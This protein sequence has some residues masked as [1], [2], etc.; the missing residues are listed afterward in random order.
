MFIEELSKQLKRND[1]I[2]PDDGGH[3]TWFMQAFKTKL[4][5]R[6]FS[7]F[8]N[9]QWDIHFPAAIG[10]SIAKNKQ[11]VI[12]IDGDGSFQINVQRI[13]NCCK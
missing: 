7:A 12:C 4:G 8:G 13:T 10:A 9:S 1:I 3:L 6:V 5:Q 11:R 2:I